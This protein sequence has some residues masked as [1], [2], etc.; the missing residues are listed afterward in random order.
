MVT[1]AE[2]QSAD[3]LPLSQHH[4]LQIHHPHALVLPNISPSDLTMNSLTA[5]ELQ[6]R[7]ASGEEVDFEQT[8]FTFIGTKGKGSKR[9]KTKRNKE[10][11]PTVAEEGLKITNPNT[12]ASGQP[13]SSAPEPAPAPQVSPRRPVLSPFQSHASLNQSTLNI[14]QATTQSSAPL[15]QASPPSS[16]RSTHGDGQSVTEPHAYRKRDRFAMNFLCYSPHERWA[17]RVDSAKGKKASK[18]S[19]EEDSDSDSENGGRAGWGCF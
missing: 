3:S 16:T 18:K 8:G 10:P 17:K 1:H 9:N 4:Y 14:N 11:L 15:P 2:P 6:E 5:E 12:N 7:I 19:A 13:S